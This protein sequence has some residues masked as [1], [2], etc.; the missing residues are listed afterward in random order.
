MKE[1]CVCGHHKDLHKP[2]D[3]SG[4]LVPENCTGQT[5]PR[6]S[7]SIYPELVGKFDFRFGP[8]YCGCMKLVLLK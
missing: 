1:F 4:K 3:V 2:C 7:Q 5:Y 8:V 6:I